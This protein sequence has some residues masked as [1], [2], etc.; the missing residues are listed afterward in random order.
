MTVVIDGT[1][2]ID[3]PEVT[4]PGV[5]FG[6]TRPVAQVVT[7]QTGAVATGSTIMPRDDTIP[8]ITEGDQYMSLAI[9]PVDATSTLEID[10]VFCYAASTGN[11]CV[12][13]LFQDSVVN[14][15]AA[16]TTLAG[17]A[18]VNGQ[19]TLKHIM[20]AGTTSTTTFKLR[21]GCEVSATLTFNGS[22]GARLLGGVMASRITIKEYL[23]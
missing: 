7:F 6:N 8:Q 1:T 22:G 3:A 2:G 14:A 17:S 12:A 11:H 13:A 16:V 5:V 23:P 21:A 9:T 19:M 15:L 10:I 18:G 20:T 4:I